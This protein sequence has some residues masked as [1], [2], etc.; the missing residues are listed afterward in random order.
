MID[1]KIPTILLALLLIPFQL[2]FAQKNIEITLESAWDIAINNSYDVRQL[3]LGVER[4]RK[5]LEAERAD[6]KSRIYMRLRAPEINQVADYRWDSRLQRDVLIQQNTQ[7]WQV[8]LAIRQPVILFGYPT[9][10]YL[11]LNNQMYKYIQKNGQN[12]TNFYN[13]YFI[14]YEQPFFQ[15]NNLKNNLEDAELDLEDREIDFLQDIVRML[16]DV[17]DDYF[18]LFRLSYRGTIYSNQVE[19]LE[20]A[21][22]VAAEITEQD[23]SRIIEMNQIQVELSNAEERLLQ[24]RSDLR[25]RSARLKQDLRLSESDSLI[26][27]PTINITAVDV[28][29]ENAV[30]IGYQH[31]PIVRELDIIKRKRELDLD[32]TKGW[33][34]FR[35]NLEV[36][37][38]LEKQDDVYANLWQ[39]QDNSYSVTLN[40]YVPLV[41]WGQQKARL[42]ARKISIQSMELRIE[43][44][45]NNI[46]SQI[47]NDIA[48]LKEYEQR[49]TNMQKNMRMAK[50]ISDVSI[51][52]YRDGR[53][54]LQDLLQ[55]IERQ[56]E[57][58]LNFLEAYLGYRRS[59]FSLTED[60]YYDFEKDMSLIESLKQYDLGLSRF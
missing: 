36:T 56:R 38:G 23:S 5:W 49:A 28:E 20:Q 8:D 29:V 33:N 25:L 7:R 13:R 21:S 59:L 53:I 14:K 11:S 30:Q 48:N 50:E 6:L 3:Q 37:Y 2:S 24:N 41:D 39:E 47:T 10:G 51:N 19:N 15:P 34:S 60:T 18:D 17:A 35:V 22:A 26:I 31:R 9:N 52:Q 4:S 46:R 54:T 43:E 12:D 55:T 44:T 57:T 42:E 32:N 27:K 40:A 58:E 1:T 45:Q 16:D